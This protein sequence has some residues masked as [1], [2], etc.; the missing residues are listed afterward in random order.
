MTASRQH[1]SPNFQLP[2]VP[3]TR[4]EL[5]IGFWEFGL[6]LCV[7][8]VCLGTAH[9]QTGEVIAEVRVHGNH[10]TPDAEI[11]AIAALA[12]GEPATDAR[13]NEAAARLRD[14]GRFAAIE[15]RRR[16][17]SLDDPS[18]ILVMLV[19]DEHD[20]VSADVPIPGPLAKMRAAGMW[21]PILNY[22]DGYGL[23]YGARTS[24]VEPLGRGS[25]ISIPA[26]WG[27][28]RKLGVEVD[29]PAKA[30]GLPAEGGSYSGE[31]SDVASG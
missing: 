19:V 13:L 1:P 8:V 29:L 31:G 17:H 12:V 28:E 5:G 4:W 11:L 15:I 22:A 20:A 23:T 24:F 30:G 16:F 9:A 18:A 3:V 27:G 21:L 6:C 26:S 7:S 25:R 2:K 14:S 10:T